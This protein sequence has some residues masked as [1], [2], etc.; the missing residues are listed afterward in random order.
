MN[1]AYRQSLSL[2]MSL[3]FA[4][5]SLRLL[6]LTPTTLSHT[7]TSSTLSLSLSLSL[8]HASFY[9]MLSCLYVMLC[10]PSQFEA[11]GQ[12]PASSSFPCARFCVLG[13]AVYGQHGF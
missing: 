2:P 10:G 13:L 11:L 6:S 4:I 1:T 12:S 8:S 3:F 5:Y 9:V 7:S